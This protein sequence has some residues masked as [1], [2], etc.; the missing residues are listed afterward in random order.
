ME[1]SGMAAH[2]LCKASHQG[3]VSASVEAFGIRHV[4]VTVVPDKGGTLHEQAEEALNSLDADLRANHARGSVVAQTVFLAEPE[5]IAECRETLNN[6]Y[7]AELPAT[8]YVP[9]AP[10]AGSLLALE[11]HGVA[12]GRS[13]VEIERASDQLVLF[14]HDGLRWG[15]CSPSSAG[16]S[17]DGAYETTASTLHRTCSLLEGVGLRFDQVLRTWLYL[18]GIV[19]PEG[20]T[21]RYKELNR[22]RA[23]YYQDILFLAEYQRG[24]LRGPTF[25]ASTGIGATGRELHASI[26]AL[27]SNRSDVIARSVENPR[28]TSAYD[29]AR[30]YSPQSPRFSRAMALSCGP[31]CL[32]FVSGT[33][34]ITQSE[35]RHHGD[36][37]AQTHETLDNVEALISEANLARHDL[38]GFGTSLAGLGVVRVYVKRP[39]DYARVKEACTLRLH[40]APITYTIADVCRPELL[41]EIEGI[42]F[43]N[44]QPNSTT[45]ALRGPHFR[46]LAPGPA[47]SGRFS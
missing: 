12:R 35:S 32:I 43:A 40:G 11:A 33:A 27:A 41:V 18:G 36:A 14:R 24:P 34:S 10:C 8:T 17:A 30:S 4:L 37:V 16:V 15:Y 6:F 29:Y 2:V 5:S 22:A 20:P 25:P 42:A 46:K 44:R 26:L 45:G 47:G 3:T 13:D 21:Q 9:Q 7:G 19:E 31:D 38:P 1:E 28:Q 23:D 39:D